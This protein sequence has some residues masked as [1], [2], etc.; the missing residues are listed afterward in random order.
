MTELREFSDKVRESLKVQSPWHVYLYS[1]LVG[2]FVGFGAI[3]FSYILDL[4]IEWVRGVHGQEFDTH[5]SLES[6]MSDLMHWSYWQQSHVWFLI[7]FPAIGGLLSGLASNYLAKETLGIGMDYL[8]HSFHRKEGKLRKR[9]SI[10]RTI[11]TWFTISGGGSAGKEGPIAQ[12]GAGLGVIVADIFKAGQR[13][14]RT[15]LLAGASAGLG[16]VFKA[17]LGGALTTVEM[18]YKEDIESEAVIPCF[19][20]SVVA[21]LVYTGYAGT[22][23]LFNV[24]TVA[25]LHVEELLFY[26]LLGL[27]C[28]GFGFLLVQGYH[29]S[30]SWIRRVP[31]A[32][33]VKPAFGGLLVGLIS[34]LFYEVTGIGEDFTQELFDGH[35]PSY[36]GMEA[37]QVA[38]AFLVIALIKVLATTLTLGSGG[39]GGIFGP[40]LFIGGMLGAAV[41]SLAQYFYPDSEIFIS[42]YIMVGMGAFYAGLASASL[43]GIVMICEITGNYLLLPPLILATVFTRILS[44][45]VSLLKHKEKNRFTS[46]AHAADRQATEE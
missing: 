36:F 11:A 17:P 31:V 9:Y 44:N 41:G 45:K 18:V 21:F 27:L 2:L 13:A 32:N 39:S 26:S 37:W 8:I 20:S 14:R 23:K 22:E 19:I 29:N 25:F 5:R 40:S 3:G 16:A 15:L 24:G 34:L 35:F 42:S 6:K 1:A 43:A 38:L 10:V 4:G 33:W 46:P 28:F 12:I 7:L 30:R